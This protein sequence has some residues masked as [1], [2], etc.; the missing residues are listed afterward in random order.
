MSNIFK[1]GDKVKL[2]QGKYRNERSNP[3]DTI[4]IIIT[5]RKGEKFQMDCQVLWANGIRN[6]YW[7]SDL[8]LIN[9]TLIIYPDE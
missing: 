9:D 6:S 7:F 3:L 1:K 2:I 8:E 5:I 4:G